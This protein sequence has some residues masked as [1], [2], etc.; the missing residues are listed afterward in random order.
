MSN[1]LTEKNLG[2]YLTIIFKTEFINNMQIGKY[3]VD[4]YSPKL[5]IGVEFD[6][7]RHYNDAM[8]QSRDK[9]KDSFLQSLGIIVMRIPYFIQLSTETINSLLLFKGSFNTPWQQEYPHGFIDPK[10]L[11]PA[12]FNEIGVRR[13]LRDLDKIQLTVRDE[14]INS[15]IDRAQEVKLK[16]SD[17]EKLNIIVP[18]SLTQDFIQTVNFSNREELLN[19]L[20]MNLLI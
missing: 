17:A 9:L 12:D 20:Q 10:T 7:Y 1:Y 2:E 8:T 19:N 4:W 11:K 13:F 16:I 5:S 14:I 15:L 3:R 6:G 18:L